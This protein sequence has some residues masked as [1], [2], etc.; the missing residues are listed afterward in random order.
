MRFLEGERERF[1]SSSEPFEKGPWKKKFEV[2]SPRSPE[3]GT[4]QQ[5]RFFNP[6]C[7]TDTQAESEREVIDEKVLSNWVLGVVGWDLGS[8]GTES[9]DTCRS[10]GEVVPRLGRT[11]PVS[12]F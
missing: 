2:P 8:E 6:S 4:G 5:D 11:T 12:I 1:F 10:R 7:V 9:K 3:G